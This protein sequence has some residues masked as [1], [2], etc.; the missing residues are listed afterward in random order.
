M[1]AETAS[2][3]DWRDAARYAA[4]L[5][6]DRSLF[7]WEW[8]RRHPRYRAAATRA[9]AAGSAGPAC[10]G[11]EEFGLVAF[12]PPRSAVPRARPLWRLAVHPY[13]LAAEPCRA[14]LDRFDLE[15]LRPLATVVEDN[16]GEHLLLCDGLRAIRLDGPRG[17]FTG[18]PARLRYVLD[19]LESAQPPL[20][21]LRRLLALCRNGRF[22]RSLH[23]REVRARRWILMLRTFDALD[24]GA[25]QRE[26]ARVLL[27]P[28]VAGQAWRS[29]EPS[30]RSQ[31]QR[32]VGTARRMAGGGYSRLLR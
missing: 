17:A 1:Q 8:L 3:C 2:G 22:S 13:V 18:G 16:A 10:R 5:D 25:D 19:G 28:S 12:E 15:P 14:P 20:L 9:L 6:A 23:A 4:L 27:S 30:I 26:I 31:V 7:A 29:R 21:T 32:L 24:S 11:A